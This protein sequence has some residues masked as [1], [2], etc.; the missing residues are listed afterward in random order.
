MKMVNREMIK[1]KQIGIKRS[2]DNF[3]MLVDT[4]QRCCRYIR[5]HCS[6]TEY[7]SPENEPLSVAKE[8][9]AVWGRSRASRNRGG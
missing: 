4:F 7:A 1:L 8:M 3:A 6:I 5:N 2:Y 9:G